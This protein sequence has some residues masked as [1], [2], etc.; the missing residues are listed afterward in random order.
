MRNVIRALDQN[1]KFG[2]KILSVCSDGKDDQVIQQVGRGLGHIAPK[3]PVQVL[4]ILRKWCKKKEFHVDPG[5]KRTANRAGDGDIEKIETYLLGWISKEKNTITMLCHLPHILDEVYKGK[6]EELLRLLKKIDFRHKRNS[7]LIGKTLEKS[8]SEGYGEIER[9]ESFLSSCNEILMRIAVHKELEVHIETDATKEP[10]V[11]TLELVSLVYH[12]KK[13]IPSSEIK[14]NLKDF[15]N[16]VSFFGK[17]RL[18]RLIEKKP[19]HPLVRILSR[20]S[21]SED[22]VKQVLKRIDKQDKLWQKGMMWHAVKSRY[23]PVSMFCDMDASFAMFTEH[24]QG[25]TSIR[26][27]MLDENQFLSNTH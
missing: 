25:K 12:G 10:V 14:K 4:K 22:R 18:E 17:N 19:Y 26:K 2:A 9:E 16:V 7:T 11:Y 13:K 5:L 15:P 3:Y 24:E 23:Y 27:G 6:D 20:I 8:L 1:E 21:V